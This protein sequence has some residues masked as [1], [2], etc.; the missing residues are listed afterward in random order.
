MPIEDIHELIEIFE[1]AGELRKISTQVDSELEVA[2]ILRRTMYNNG[3]ALLFENVKGL[4]SKKEAFEIIINKKT[5]NWVGVILTPGPLPGIKDQIFNHTGLLQ[6]IVQRDYLT[7][8]E[9]ISLSL[10]KL[11]VG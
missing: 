10:S 11:H 2:E 4:I 8:P 3:P 6:K 5:K 9:K 1:K 7:D